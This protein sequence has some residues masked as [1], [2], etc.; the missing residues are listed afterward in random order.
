MS[1]PDSKSS[2]FEAGFKAGRFAEREISAAATSKPTEQKP[3]DNY[4]D[5]LAE[6][7]NRKF[8]NPPEKHE[9]APAAPTP[10]TFAP[11]ERLTPGE[12]A[13]LSDSDFQRYLRSR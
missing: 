12:V 4:G 13:N 3:G 9:P 6:E 10:R 8:L 11:G 7:T 2:D 5:L 1:E